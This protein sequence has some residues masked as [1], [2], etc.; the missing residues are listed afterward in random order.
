MLFNKYKESDIAYFRPSESEVKNK[1]AMPTYTNFASQVC[2]GLYEVKGK[3]QNQ[4]QRQKK[5][6]SY[7]NI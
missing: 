7:G 6:C 3:N 5:V 1:T 2:S 4:N